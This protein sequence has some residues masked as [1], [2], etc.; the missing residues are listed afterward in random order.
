MKAKLGVRSAWCR[1][2]QITGI[3]SGT[4]SDLARKGRR[5]LT[6]SHKQGAGREDATPPVAP[7]RATRPR[8]SGAGASSGSLALEVPAAAPT[9]PR[10]DRAQQLDSWF[11]SLNANLY[12]AHLIQRPPPGALFV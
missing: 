10:P 1:S 3:L 12:I 5:A 6:W 4:G 8:H 2:T 9:H 11:D 7:D